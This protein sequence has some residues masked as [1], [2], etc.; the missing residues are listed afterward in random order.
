[1]IPWKEKFAIVAHSHVSLETVDFMALDPAY[2][3]ATPNMVL[4]T[5]ACESV[6]ASL[7]SDVSRSDISF[8]LGTHFGEIE[9]S[10]EFLKTY[11]ETQTPR[12][13][14]FQNSLHNSTLGFATIHLG[15]TGP[16]LTISSGSE[17][18]ASGLSL[19]EN[20]LSLTSYAM[21]CFVDNIPKPIEHHYL[22]YMPELKTFVN[23]AHCFLF[24]TSAKQKHLNLTDL[25]QYKDFFPCSTW[26]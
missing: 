15:L 6:L 14:L 11:Y 16:A 24:T 2:R 20:L 23:Q 3:R 12:P 5:R 10:L 4:A 22:N 1:M 19:V 18:V 21:L 7:P 25:T 13:I 9:A 26:E 17:T 8:V